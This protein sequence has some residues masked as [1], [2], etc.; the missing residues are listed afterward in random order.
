MYFQKEDE[1]IRV[2]IIN[3]PQGYK[4]PSNRKRVCTWHPLYFDMIDRGVAIC[5]LKP[6]KFHTKFNQSQHTE[7]SETLSQSKFP[8]RGIRVV[9]WRCLELYFLGNLASVRIWSLSVHQS[10]EI[11]KPVTLTSKWSILLF[12]TTSVLCR[13]I[14]NKQMNCLR[15]PK[16][17]QA[18]WDDGVDT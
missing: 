1:V 8:Y 16:T 15:S 9:V 13:Q 18:T 12:G 5:H 3:L 11:G 14:D 17:N 7:T 6:L 2:W 10:H 4:T